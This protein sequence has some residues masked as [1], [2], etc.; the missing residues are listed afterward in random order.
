MSKY[1]P[2]HR[3]LNGLKRNLITVSFEHIESTICDTLPKS[4]R[5]YKAWWANQ[6][7]NDKRPQTKAW[8]QADF[9]VEEC[10]LERQRVSF[11]RRL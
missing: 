3:W 2:L 5:R 6:K 7:K 11:R 10:D 4:A 9:E 8:M 1:E